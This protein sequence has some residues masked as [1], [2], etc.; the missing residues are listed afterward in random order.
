MLFGC[1]IALVK[2]EVIKN[3]NA[4]GVDNLKFDIMS[5]IITAYL[6]IDILSKIL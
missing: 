1:Y 3:K 5:I 6:L 4:D 2:S